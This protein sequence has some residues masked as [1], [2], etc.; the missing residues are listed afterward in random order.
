VTTKD[1]ESS[2]YCAHTT[3]FRLKVSNLPLNFATTILGTVGTLLTLTVITVVGL[4]LAVWRSQ[5]TTAVTQPSDDPRE[6]LFGHR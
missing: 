5:Q 6:S 1:A 3:Q 4:F 2:S